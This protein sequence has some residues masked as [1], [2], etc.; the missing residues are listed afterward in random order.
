[1]PRED[2]DAGDDVRVHVRPFAAAL[3][4][5]RSVERNA[6]DDENYAERDYGG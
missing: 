4:P 5:A 2:D 3:L 6:D 1:V